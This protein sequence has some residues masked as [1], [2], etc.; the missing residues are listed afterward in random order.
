MNWST[1]MSALSSILSAV[2]SLFNSGYNVW[3]QYRKEKLARELD[4]LKDNDLRSKAAA[5]EQLQK[6]K[7]TTMES[8]NNLKVNQPIDVENRKDLE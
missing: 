3:L 2:A 4:R 1:V 8:K 5:E 6:L 7:E